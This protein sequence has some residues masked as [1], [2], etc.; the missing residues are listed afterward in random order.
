MAFC[1]SASQVRGCCE[2][3][4]IVGPKKRA[5]HAA[6]LFPR[7]CAALRS[8]AR[9]WTHQL[10]RLRARARA[11]RLRVSQ[12]S[13]V[14]GSTFA[15]GSARLTV[16]APARAARRAAPQPRAMADGAEG[17][18][19]E[20]MWAEARAPQGRNPS[21][22]RRDAQPRLHAP[23]SAGA[24][25]FGRGRRGPARRAA[26]LRRSSARSRQQPTPWPNAL[27]AHAAC[28]PPRSATTSRA[29]AL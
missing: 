2:H 27:K 21:Q 3:W 23:P 13:A 15:T 6:R 24:L 7:S 17:A 1:V 5:Q 12:M 25:L 4:R 20:T 8:H 28:P 11:V 29:C 14:R 10:T 19:K 9:P 22:H 18:K 16:A 26:G